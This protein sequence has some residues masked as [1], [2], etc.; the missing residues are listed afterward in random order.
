MRLC[1]RS[2]AGTDVGDGGVVDSV[3]PQ[4]L[5]G[6]VTAAVGAGATVA[7]VIYGPAWKDRVDARRASRQRSEHLLA[8]YSEP[9]AR[10]A[11]DLQSRLYNMYRQG[12]LTA[13]SIPE[14]YRRMST[15]WLYGQFLAWIEIVRREVQVIDFGDVRRTAE[16]QRHLFDV[17]DIVAS[18]SIPD[19]GFR[20]FRA[21]QRAIGEGMVTERSTGELRRSDSLGYAEFVHRME[22][23]PAFARWFAGLDGD[24]TALVNGKSL[25][26]RVV[27]TQRALV[28]LINFLDPDWIRF[29]DP[30]ERGKLPLPS[31]VMDRKR[32]RPPTEVARFRYET[33][34]VPLLASWANERGLRLERCG[35]SGARVAL[36]RGWRTRRRD[37]LLLSSPPWVELHV[38]PHGHDLGHDRSSGPGRSVLSRTQIDALNSLLHRFDRPTLPH[39]PPRH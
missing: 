25:G 31:G 7:A 33:D 36:G 39:Q 30:N 6:L 18:D 10:A 8:R 12:F 24:I 32:T 2:Q 34:P 4:L 21:D 9:L 16:L 27:L 29:P 19:A 28:D 38:V 17:V 23:D 5:T 13:S 14:P 26:T 1:A 22:T 20:I 35:K 15:L 37:V 11:F 3:D